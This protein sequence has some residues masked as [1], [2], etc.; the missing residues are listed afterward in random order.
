MVAPVYVF[1]KVKRVWFDGIGFLK[2]LNNKKLREVSNGE[3]G[4]D[5]FKSVY[6][7]SIT[8]KVI[9]KT[10]LVFEKIFLYALFIRT[11]FIKKM[12]LKIAK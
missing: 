7:F 5:Q 3:K 6:L 4:Q 12:T 8:L 10:I 9:E 2:G 11:I 1:K